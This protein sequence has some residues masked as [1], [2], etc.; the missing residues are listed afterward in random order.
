MAKKYSVKPVTRP[1]KKS[2]STSF[3]D[4]TGTRRI[5]GLGTKGREHAQMICA[6]LVYL[7]TQSCS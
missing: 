6:G 7:H 3:Y 2:Y 1:G 5:R 4:A